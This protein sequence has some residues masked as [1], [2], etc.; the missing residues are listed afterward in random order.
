MLSM[1]K[2]LASLPQVE[3]VIFTEGESALTKKVELNE[4]RPW[5]YVCAQ[6]SNLAC[7]LSRACRPANQKTRGMKELH[8]AGWGAD[9]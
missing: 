3:Q 2:R 9:P 6:N 8:M 7:L 4:R 5:L 1:H